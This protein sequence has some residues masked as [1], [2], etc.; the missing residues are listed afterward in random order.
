MTTIAIILPAYNEAA[1]IT[2]CIQAF[3]QARPDATIVVVDNNS[4]DGTG[5]IAAQAIND[6]GIRGRVIHEPRQ[7]KANAIR[8]AFSEIDVDIYAM[9]DADSTYP[10]E[11]LDQLILPVLD[12]RAD[13]VVGDRLS[14]GAYS[15]QNERQFHGFGNWLVST[16]IN[17]LFGV[18][19]ADVMS[20]YRVMSRAFVENYPCL[21]DG[22]ELE[23]DMTLF[24]IKARFRTLEIPIAYYSRP[25]GSSSKLNTYRDGV[26][27]LRIIVKIF[28]Y[29]K[30]LSFFGWLSC[31]VA[32][33]G[34][35]AGYPAIDDWITS[36]Y[37]RH[38]PLA[39]LATGLEI[40]ALLSLAIGLV[41]DAVAYHQLESL[42]R[43]LR[44]GK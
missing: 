19:V 1:T 23:T 31:L 4:T 44:K 20:G 8:R 2:S 22:F 21:V 32:I 30:P 24:A 13:I 11:A 34:I 10:P 28:R 40:S 33:L 16:L 36:G 29:Y 3:S 5:E 6:L 26:K 9:A 39:I 14:S 35:V 25:Q 17:K 15:T 38:V 41:L 7:G 18:S 27:V 37:V 12:E 42:E 43:A